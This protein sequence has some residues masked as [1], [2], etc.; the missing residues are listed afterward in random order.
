[1][2]CIIRLIACLAV[3]VGCSMTA[4]ALPADH[5]AQHSRLSSG[6]WIKLS[7]K[8]SGPCL[9]SSSILKSNGFKNTDAV[10]V[11]GYPGYRQDDRLTAALTT[12]DLPPVPTVVTPAGVVFYA[13]APALITY[14][15]G[16]LDCEPSVYTDYSYYFVTESDEAAPQWPVTGKPANDG[17]NTALAVSH[18]E[19]DLDTPGEAGAHLVGEDFKYTSLRQFKIPTRMAASDGDA[20]LACSFVSNVTAAT[21]NLNITATGL[22]ANVQLEKSVNDSKYYGYESLSFNSFKLKSDNPTVSLTFK[23]G[24][25]C[26]GAWLNYLTLTYTCQLKLTDGYLLFYS[27]APQLALDCT[28]AADVT[29]WDVTDPVNIKRVDAFRRDNKLCWSVTEP[30]MRHYAAFAGAASLNT[31][32][33]VTTV[34]NQDLHALTEADMIIYT[35]PQWADQA[36]RLAKLHAGAP[37]SLRTHVVDINQVYNEFGSGAPDVSA[38]RRLN[39]MLYDRG[40]GTKHPLK[41]VLLMGSATFDERHHLQATRN[42]RGYSIPSWQTRSMTQ[43][44]S[45]NSG[46]GTDD[47]VGML[48]DYRNETLGSAYISVAVGRMA[49]NSHADAKIAVDKV[50]KYINASKRGTWRNRILMCSDDGNMG[51]HTTQSEQ[52]EANLRTE[53]DEQY[54]VNK[55]YTDAY[56]Y[57]GMVPTAGRNEMFRLLREGVLLWTYVGHG[58]PSRWSDNDILVTSDI[59]NFYAAQSPV[60][61]AATCDFLRWDSNIIS[62]AEIMYLKQAGGLAAV[63]SATRPVN[64]ADN[65]YMTN[66]MGHSMGRRDELGRHY[67]LGEIYRWAKNNLTFIDGNGIERP[68]TVN[69]NRLRYVLLGDPAMRLPMPDLL[70]RVDSLN[71]QPM[72]KLEAPQIKARQLCRIAGSVVNP[73]TKAVVR[74]FNG[75]VQYDL[76]DATESRTTKDHEREDKTVTFDMPGQRLASGGGTVTNGHFNFTIAMPEQTS[77]NWRTASL[78]LL[79]I[80]DKASGQSASVSD[81]AG[82]VRSIY[83]Y[84]TDTKVAQDT[85]APEIELLALNHKSYVHGSPVHSTPTILAEVT[86]DRGINLSLRG[87]GRQ[88]SATID[89]RTS[90]S[91]LA[92]YFTPYS[93]GRIGGSLAYPLPALTDGPHTLRLRVWDTDG[94][95]SEANTQ[96]VVDASLQ[97]QILDVTTDANPATEQATFYV[98]HNQPDAMVSMTLSIYSLDGRLVWSQT[99]SGRSDSNQVAPVT[100]PLTDGT[101]RRVARGIYLYRVSLSTKDGSSYSTQARKIAVAPL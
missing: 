63:I 96:F 6:R 94:N 57:D 49:V 80:N 76:Y 28:A 43:S 64:I 77:Q 17:V 58:N 92:L 52:F 54:L 3:A 29:V 48:E 100:W 89:G 86:D 42:M 56:D 50:E 39:K 31:P 88:M 45:S 65:A 24:A 82:L 25:D 84:D 23:P 53:A 30:G 36:Q 20:T 67:P 19:N 15:D 68:V 62:G 18:Y 51:V 21:S 85:I 95:L 69:T 97:P 8:E 7:V 70:V 91:D 16:R 90:Y 32:A 40:A 12:D 98:T 10:R 87:V 14:A 44:L 72:D 83:V 33:G 75:T 66:A 74:D 59:N 34:A 13:G 61:Y 22:N 55:M 81:A 41:Y 5:F 2:S 9:I 79:A 73:V 38:I 37:D 60:L 46:F 4:A 71:G 35:Y 47:F 11:Y 1:M 78:N 26:Q 99:Q 27:D 93:D 101:G